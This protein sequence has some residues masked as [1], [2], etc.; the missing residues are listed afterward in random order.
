MQPPL[1]QNNQLWRD[2]I[3]RD[4]VKRER[5]ERE[6]KLEREEFARQ[7]AEF[8]RTV[9]RDYRRCFGRPMPKPY[10]ATVASSF[11]T[12]TLGFPMSTPEASCGTRLRRAPIPS[13]CE[14][15]AAGGPST[16]SN[17][18]SWRKRSDLAPPNS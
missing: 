6:E 17:S 18:W 1:F 4:A 16:L 11:G 5:E 7:T 15:K 14:W 13:S 10:S 8:E 12:V 3:A 2:E 9:E